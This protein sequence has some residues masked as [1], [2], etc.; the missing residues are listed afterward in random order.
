MF[1]KPETKP[2]P[3]LDEKGC[4][5]LTERYLKEI[6]FYNSGY[7]EPKYNNSLVLNYLALRKIENLQNYS[8]IRVLHLENNCITKIEGIS[9][10][11]A[12]RCLF[13]HNNQIEKIE[14][15]EGLTELAT[16]NLSSNYIKTITGL[17]TLFRLENF[18]IEKNK[19]EDYNDLVGLAECRSLNVV[20]IILTRSI[21]QIIRYRIIQKRL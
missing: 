3:D 16:L 20:S 11:K 7:A 17:K 5:Y 15:L 1:D 4:T 13:L 18:Y 14:G 19:I 8:H 10:I 12:L 9:H 6:C 2:L 21:Y